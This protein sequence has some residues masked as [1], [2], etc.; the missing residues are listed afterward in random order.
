MSSTPQPQLVRSRVRLGQSTISYEMVGS[1]RPVVL[2][3]GLSG[4]TRW[5]RRNV[6]VLATQFQVYMVDLAGFGGSRGNPFALAEAAAMLAGWM[7][8]VGLERASMIGHSMGGYIVADLAATEAA[9]VDRLIL[10]DAAVLPFGRTYTQHGFGLLRELLH[11]PPA[12]VPVLLGD[13]LRAGPFTLWAAAQEIMRA[14]LRAKLPDIRAPTLVV[15]G[16]RDDVVPLPLGRA[17]TAAMPT[18]ELAVIERAGHNAM[19]DCPT[20]FNQLVLRFLNSC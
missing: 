5:W 4:S 13:A 18:S 15:W 11:L 6:P 8:V 17:L 16:A 14:D 10:V 7:D 1:G 20:Q 19:W 9:R 3:H 12:F 2:V